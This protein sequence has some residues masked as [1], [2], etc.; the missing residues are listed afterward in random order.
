MTSLLNFFAIFIALKEASETVLVLKWVPVTRTDF[1]FLIKS[2]S[3]S[4]SPV[5]GASYPNILGP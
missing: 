4:I 1:E 5:S 3:I 2:S